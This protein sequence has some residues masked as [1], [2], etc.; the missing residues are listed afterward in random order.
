MFIIIAKL[1]SPRVYH[2]VFFTHHV[3]QLVFINQ[4]AQ[5]CILHP[6]FTIVVKIPVL[7]VL[8]SPSRAGYPVF[9]AQC[10]P[11]LDHSHNPAFTTRVRCL[12]FAPRVHFTKFASRFAWLLGC[13]RVYLRDGSAQAMLRAANTE[14]E[15]ADQT[16][17]LTQ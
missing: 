17:H 13:M 1:P 11:T 8:Y 10:S 6:M 3:H 4:C 7:V 12:V 16:F 5:P 15:V 2:R 9:T 14:I